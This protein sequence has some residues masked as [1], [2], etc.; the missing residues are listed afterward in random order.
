MKKILI[1]ASN[2]MDL[3]ISSNNR[4][5]YLPQFLHDNGYDVEVVTTDFNHHRKEH[6]KETEP[7]KYKLTLLHELG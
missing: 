1:V 6:V 7:R 5:N 4:T 3:K 2:Y